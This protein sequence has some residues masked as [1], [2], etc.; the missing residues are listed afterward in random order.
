VPLFAFAPAVA[1]L[2]AIQFAGAQ[3]V[4]Q[5]PPNPTLVWSD[6]FRYT[7]APDPARW[8]YEYGF[9]R[10]H[11]SQFYT[12]NRLQNARVENGMLVIEAR[13]EHYPNPDF[14]PTSKNPA[15]RRPFAEYTSAS[16]ITRHRESWTFGRIEVTAKIPHGQGVWP[17]VWMLGDDFGP[18]RW[19]RCG[20][21]DIM[22]FVGHDPTHLFATVHWS[23]NG[24]LASEG[25]KIKTPAPYNDFHVYAVDWT[26]D[27]MSFFID[28][29]N[30][31]TFDVNHA[32][33]TAPANPAAPIAATGNQ[34]S[35]YANTAHS[36]DNHHDDSPGPNPFRLPQYLI[37]NL[38]LG[39][40]WGGKID[41]AILPQKYLI[42]S[43]K[44]FSP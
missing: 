44:V 13:K 31:F 28:D 30:Y 41:D 32:N 23:R 5:S 17:A 12:R 10:N 38:A 33:P 11:E 1:L 43:V 34:V 19:P 25:S 15:R 36:P 16:L 2:A 7:G 39:G 8:D 42:K 18:T 6:D 37:L 14:D 27:R 24:K 20:E 35:P 4:P 9:V 26:P 3:S 40:D 22:E 29:K 21:T